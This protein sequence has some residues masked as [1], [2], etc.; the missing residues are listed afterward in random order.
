M[1]MKRISGY[2]LSMLLVF[3]A[4]IFTDFIILGIVS[5]KGDRGFLGKDIISSVSD[6]IIYSDGEFTILPSLGKMMDEENFFVMIIDDNGDVIWDYNKPSDIEDHY[7][8]KEVASFSRWYLNDHPVYIWTRDEGLLVVGEPVGSTWKYSLNVRMNSL[9]NF[10]VILP[11]LL[12]VN[13]LILIILPVLITRKWIRNREKSRTEWIAGVSHDIRTPL[14]IVMGSVEKGS[15]S[16]KQCIKIRDLI[17]NLNTENKLESGTGKWNEEEIKIV[18][19][20]R[21]IVCDY[22]N[23]Y[24]DPYT[25]EFDFDEELEG[26]A[27]NAD[28]GLIRRMIENLISNS[29]THNEKGCNIIVS[30]KQAPK[31]RVK[32]VISDDGAGTSGIKIRTLNSKLRSDYLPEHGLGIRVV[33]QVARKYK[34]RVLFSSEEGKGFS[35]EVLIR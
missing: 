29:V 7:G 22:I 13:I 17:G 21:E 6:G 23:S 8:I 35:T 15:A 19:L 32:L 18:P 3:V 31:G 26:R 2:F 24:D 16:E 20:L 27:I 14:S 28:E 34:Y 25:F 33:K 9:E 10:F 11:V 4:L 5:I 12:I 1:M 30:L